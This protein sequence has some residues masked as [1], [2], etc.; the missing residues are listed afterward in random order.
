MVNAL[1]GLLEITLVY[2]GRFP[3][4]LYRPQIIF[5]RALPIVTIVG[6]T[7]F[8]NFISDICAVQKRINIAAPNYLA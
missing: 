2:C 6:R 5:F 8:S 1:S 7:A 4:V 3:K